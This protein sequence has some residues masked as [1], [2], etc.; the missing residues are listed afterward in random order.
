ML[1]HWVDMGHLPER[2]NMAVSLRRLQTDDQSEVD[3]LCAT[4]WDGTDYVPSR[5][6]YWASSEA[7]SVL[8]IFEEQELVAIVNLE[9]VPG[10]RIGWVEGLRVKAGHRNKGLGTRIVNAV[11]DAAQKKG[12]ELLRYATGSLNNESMAVA[13]KCGFALATE[14]GYFKLERPFPNHP[15]PSPIV[16]PLRVDAERLLELL[17]AFSEVIDV[18][19]LP[20]AWSFDSKDKAGLERIG[21]QTQFRVV[22]AEDGTMNALYYSKFVE[23]ENRMRGT[24]HVFAADRAIFVDIMSRCVDEVERSEASGASFFV[25]PRAKEWSRSLGYVSDEFDDRAFLLFE[26]QLAD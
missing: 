5:F 25:G 20:I 9:A 12:L 14:V 18:E 10:T 3:S 13:R 17:A 23:D 15:K 24:F 8:G 6:A 2:P 26:K 7:N 19:R 11:V 21:S 4:V 16:T 22:I 1:H